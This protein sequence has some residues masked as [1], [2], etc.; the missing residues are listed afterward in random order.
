MRAYVSFEKLV[1]NSN[2]FWDNWIPL[3]TIWVGSALFPRPGWRDSNRHIKILAVQP[4]FINLSKLSLPVPA[5][6]CAFTGPVANRD[7]QIREYY[8][9][10]GRLGL[11][12][13]P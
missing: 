2:S 10:M 6:S 7:G 12:F 9:Q 13:V 4:V 8:I 3:S 11:P 1:F 5:L